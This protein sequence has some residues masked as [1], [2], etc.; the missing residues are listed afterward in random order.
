MAL[1]LGKAGLLQQG[2]GPRE[3]SLGRGEGWLLG[4]LISQEGL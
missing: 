4:A 2:R 1:S 3:G